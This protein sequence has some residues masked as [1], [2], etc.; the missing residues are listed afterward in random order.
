MFR[1]EL[2]FKDSRSL[3]VV[4]TNRQQRESVNNRLQATL[5][6][7]QS[8]AA[9]ST[10]GGLLKTPLFTRFGARVLSSLRQDGLSTAQ[11]KWQAREISNVRLMLSLLYKS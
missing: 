10:P 5:G 4:F 3:L 9:P 11:R 6:L 8:T 2:Y 1:L 7:G